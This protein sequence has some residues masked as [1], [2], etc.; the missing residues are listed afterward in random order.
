MLHDRSVKKVILV[1][2]LLDGVLDVFVFRSFGFR[3]RHILGQEGRRLPVRRQGRYYV[4]KREVFLSQHGS[5]RRG[6]RSLHVCVSGE[7]GACLDTGA[8]HIYELYY[9]TGRRYGI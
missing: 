5:L 7:W 2:L 6:L 3:G 4:V 9:I 1:N 8:V